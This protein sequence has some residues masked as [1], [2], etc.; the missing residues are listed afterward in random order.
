MFG[1]PSPQSEKG[2]LESNDTRTHQRDKPFAFKADGTAAL[3]E[4]I[5]VDV[6]F[7]VDLASRSLASALSAN[8]SYLLDL[9]R[10]YD[11]FPLQRLAL[12][13]GQL[14]FQSKISQT[15]AHPHDH[16]KKQNNERGI[17]DIG[18]RTGQPC[19]SNRCFLTSYRQSAKTTMS[20]NLG[21]KQVANLVITMVA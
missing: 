8:P 5:L 21:F 6:L 3:G 9:I 11:K 2:C 13:S 17:F 14:P 10:T 12:T 19:G 7:S 20:Q 15:G 16:R 4:D 18:S 1:F